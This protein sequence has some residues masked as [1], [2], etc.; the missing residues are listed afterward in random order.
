MIVIV[1]NISTYEVASGTGNESRRTKDLTA[2]ATPTLELAQDDDTNTRYT[3]QQYTA[4]RAAAVR[5][6][7]QNKKSKKRGS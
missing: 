5:A 6:L 2:K 4:V 1:V 3:Y 7:K